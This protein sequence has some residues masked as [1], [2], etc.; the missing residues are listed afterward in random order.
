MIIL[1][2]NI[3]DV[4]GEGLTHEIAELSRL[5]HPAIISI[6]ETRVNPNRA[7]HIIKIMNHIYSFH[8]KVPLIG[9]AGGLWVL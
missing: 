2:W 6:M 8:V 5:Y 3:R 7:D 1:G 9:F 4:G